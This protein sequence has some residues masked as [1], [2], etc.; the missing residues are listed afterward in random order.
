MLKLF[1]VVRGDLSLDVPDDDEFDKENY[2]N[3]YEKLD[4]LV[5]DLRDP[6]TAIRNNQY[7]VESHLE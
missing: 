5:N 6:E 2:L 1:A 7:F 4:S 3:S